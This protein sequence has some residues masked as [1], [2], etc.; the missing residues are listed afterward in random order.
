MCHLR[1][2]LDFG[3]YTACN[4]F[5]VHGLKRPGSTFTCGFERFFSFE[6]LKSESREQ[7]NRVQNRNAAAKI[8]R[9][10]CTGDKK[11]AVGAE[12]GL[13]GDRKQLQHLLPISIS[14]EKEDDALNK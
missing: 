14:E 4:I 9:E 11:A 8:N 7:E 10:L 5:F 13:L 1:A 6:N 12:V 2:K 3:I